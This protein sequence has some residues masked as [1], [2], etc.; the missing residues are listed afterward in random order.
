M[1]HF[2]NFSPVHY[3]HP[4]SPDGYHAWISIA[5]TVH[6][7]SKAGYPSSYCTQIEKILDP[8]I[9]NTVHRIYGQELVVIAQ[10]TTFVDFSSHEMTTG[11]GIINKLGEQTF[12][13]LFHCP[14]TWSHQLSSE[15]TEN[16]ELSAIGL[17]AGP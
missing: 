7:P 9:E 8:H 10:D 13:Q 6:E 12:G 4:T 1:H 11:L 5:F 17:Y 16:N 15:K 14:I 3:S 2:V